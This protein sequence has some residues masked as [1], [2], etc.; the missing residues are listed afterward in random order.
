VYKQQLVQ[1]TQRMAVPLA[2]DPFD[3]KQQACSKHVDAYYWNEL[4]ENS[5][6]CWFMLYGCDK[7]RGQQNFEQD[8]ACR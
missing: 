4:I 2:V 1:S 8:Y 6:S 7:M 5:A 3:D